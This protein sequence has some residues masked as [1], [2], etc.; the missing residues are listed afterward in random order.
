MNLPTAFADEDLREQPRV[1][2]VDDDE[3]NLML[4]GIALR[5]RGFVITEAASGERALGLLAEPPDI[6]VLDA[7]MPGMDGFETC[8]RLR[9]LPGFENMPVLMLTGLDDDASIQRAYRAGAT[10]FFVKSTQWSLLAGRLHYLL[11]SS[12]TRQEL[13]RSKAK[14]ARAQDL[15]RMG[16]FDWRRADTSH[17]HP[18]AGG[19]SM[20]PEGLRV[21]GLGPHERLSLREV[22]RL[23]PPV[24]RRLLLR[25]LHDA[26][27]NASVLATDVP[28]TLLDG[29][30]RIVH[31][32]AEP[33]FNEHGQ[34]IGY[35]GIV[36]DVTDRRLAEDRIRHLANFDAL[37][38]LPNR[39]QLIY[40]T[41]RALE[42]ARRLGHPA[43]LLLIDLDRFKII[44]DTLGHAAGDELLVEVSRR[45][46]GCVRHSDQVM[47]GTLEAMGARSHRSLEAVGRLGGDEFVA[48]L[49]EVADERDAER[50]AN[51]VLEVMR[52]PIFVGGQECFVTASVGIAMFPRD[53]ATVAD[54]LR[55]SDVAMYS[56][57]SQGRNSATL[58]SPMLAGQG[59][60]KLELESALHKAIERDELVL[61]YQPKIDV[62]AARM[63]GAEA[64]MRWQR[65][66][67]L[68][69]PGDFI[70]L[71]EETGL[72]VPLSEWAL[73]EAARQ[74]RLW[75]VN[76]GFADSIAV[77]L[78]N[79]LFERSDLVETIHDA[80]TAYG[81]PH[82]AIQLEI[83]ETGLMKDL[84]NVIPSLHR[85][86][87]I[88]VEISI[89]DFGT[90]YSSLAYLTTLPIS[91]LKIDRS[92]VRD[93]GITPQS[94]AVVTAIIALARSLGIRVVAEGV[95]N[96]R[97]M[98]VLHRLGC[99]VMQGFLFS[100]PIPPDDLEQWL[101]QTVLPRKAPWIGRADE[102]R[103]GELASEGPRLVS[104]A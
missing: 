48:L 4:T 41:E 23:V 24:E 86:N 16:S 34:S 5:E 56:V 50:V 55:N 79:R 84:Q 78:P 39:R 93:L 102:L 1:L 8:R 75:Q 95:E 47:D 73:R 51:R 22:L 38:G 33:E 90:G 76:F 40:R 72:I 7:L 62:R 80:V 77:N 2:L 96:L 26:I 6:I 53:G 36:Q 64:L 11:R 43:A 9:E 25:V 94:S 104:G 71:A 60:E 65:G 54:L 49:P 92:F 81:V 66:G 45:L 32:E 28:V 27:S 44:N 12:R 57:K 103:A 42:L 100:R 17:A 67:T 99:T 88:G 15:A 82:R 97:Q 14:L 87:E 20:S 31:V 19:L 85:L 89:D 70:P 91:E 30:Q 35:T 61:H 29:R 52:E 63:V 21:F 74:A 59:R 69:P 58:Y 37:T 10:D 13:E 83:T 46:R 3:V 18:H 98:D 68:V 101:K